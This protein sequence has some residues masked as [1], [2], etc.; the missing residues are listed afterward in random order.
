MPRNGSHASQNRGYPWDRR[1]RNRIREEIK[2]V[3][4]LSRDF[5]KLIHLK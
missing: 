5:I 4:T 2:E 3:S 1:E